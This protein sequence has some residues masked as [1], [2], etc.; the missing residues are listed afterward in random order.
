MILQ[1]I[2]IPVGK[3]KCSVPIG[4]QLIGD[5]YDEAKLL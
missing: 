1:A 3:A 4:L 5:H 2:S